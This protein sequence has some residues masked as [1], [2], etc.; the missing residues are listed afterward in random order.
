LER[1]PGVSEDRCIFVKLGGKKKEFTSY[2]FLIVWK[3]MPC[4]KA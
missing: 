2:C 1:L 3:I 4:V